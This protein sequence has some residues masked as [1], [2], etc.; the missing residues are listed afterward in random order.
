MKVLNIIL[1]LLFFALFFSACQKN[2]GSIKN[3]EVNTTE[4]V[5]QDLRQVRA[6]IKGMTCEIGCARLIQSK[7]YKTEGVTAASVSFADSSGVITYDANRVSAEDLKAIIEGAGGGD[8][9]TVAAIYDMP[10]DS[11]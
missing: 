4:A 9:Y 7:L 5:P 8:I 3:A 11:R 2:S 10:E 1:P 6:E